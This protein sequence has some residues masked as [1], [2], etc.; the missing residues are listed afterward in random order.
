MCIANVYFPV[1]DIINLIIKPSFLIKPFFY[2]TKKLEQQPKY[3]KTESSFSGE[4]KLFLIIFKGISFSK[5]CLKPESAP[6][7]KDKNNFGCRVPNMTKY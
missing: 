3:L 6:L 7:R 5:N 1:W 4:I 2:M